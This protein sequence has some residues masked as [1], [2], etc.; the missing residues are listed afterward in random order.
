MCIGAFEGVVKKTAKRG[1]PRKNRPEDEKRIEK[2]SRTRAKNKD[3]AMSSASSTSGY[4][5][6]S[7]ALSPR[8]DV[9]ALDDCT[10]DELRTINTQNLNYSKHENQLAECV[11]PQ[12]IQAHS[13]SVF[14]SHTM[15]RTTSRQDSMSSPQQLPPLPASPTKSVLSYHSPPG[16]CESSSSPA[17]S[18]YYELDNM[19]N[20]EE[21]LSKLSLANIAEADEMFLE[22][23]GNGTDMTALERD[24]SLLLGKFEDA[25]NQSADMFADPSDV[26][27]GSP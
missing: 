14:S 2:S 18:Q 15:S 19:S 26:F 13:P 4:S 22:A 11:S 16:L 27:F 1:R 21:D 9:E 17:P 7:G 5:E 12:A 10:F 6:S 20:P 3:K 8:S 25:Y 24:P 23:F